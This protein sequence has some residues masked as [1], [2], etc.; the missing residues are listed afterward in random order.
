[1]DEREILALLLRHEEAGLAAALEQY[2]GRLR[3]LAAGI[4][5]AETA[6]ECVSDALYA[7]WNVIPP[8]EPQHLFAFLCKLTRNFAL[9]RYRSATA[10]KR[11]G[12]VLLQS[13]EELA[14]CIPADSDPSAE[15]QAQAL[16]AAINRFLRTQPTRER[17]VFLARYFYAMPIREI[18]A[19][20]GL[21]EGT[22][23]TVLRRTRLRLRH[24]LEQ[25]EFL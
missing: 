12:A 21:R 14:A 22:V 3:S 1:M 18:A 7:A 10:Q 6:E 2:G 15:V 25:E 11:G 19:R 20:L 13:L 17:T 23:K 24:Y 5:G 8:T 9:D 16:Q 4:A